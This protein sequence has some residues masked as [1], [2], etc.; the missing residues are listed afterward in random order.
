MT[1]SPLSVCSDV[2][3][4]KGLDNHS[5]IGFMFR[6]P[7][8]SIVSDKIIQAATWAQYVHVDCVFIPSKTNI[9]IEKDLQPV[10]SYFITQGSMMQSREDHVM[11]IMFSTY[12]SETFGYYVPK[13][14]QHRS[15]DT[16]SM[17]ILEVHTEE[18]IHA[19]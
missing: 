17:L 6:K 12:I 2:P 8:N 9:C 13:E 15:N 10:P 18:F 1:T 11:K 14:W 3:Q 4:E 16:H 19:W 7:D 5:Y